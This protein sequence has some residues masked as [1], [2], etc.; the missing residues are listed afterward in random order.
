[1]L[2]WPSTDYGVE[3]GAGDVV[4]FMVFETH[5]NGEDLTP[6]PVADSGRR[7]SDGALRL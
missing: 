7:C 3:E 2:S 5:T 4:R 1:M 6:I